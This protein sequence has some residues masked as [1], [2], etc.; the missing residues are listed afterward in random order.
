MNA[1]LFVF[2]KQAIAIRALRQDKPIPVVTPFN[3]YPVWTG[4][5]PDH[6]RDRLIDHLTNPQEFWG[7]Y[8]LPT[9]SRAEPVYEPATMWRGPIWANINYIMIEALQ[10]VGR[11]DLAESLLY[12][13]LDLIASQ[14]GIHE[15]Y[16]SRTGEP[17]PQAAPAFGWTAAV[18]VDLA[19]RANSIASS[20][21]PKKGT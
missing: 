7:E 5:L 11:T 10:L 19:I 3:L 8:V 15:Y 16:D 18:F 6:I 2:K 12:K 9:V 20:Q 13:T 17:A 21:H 4:Q 1:A 14:A